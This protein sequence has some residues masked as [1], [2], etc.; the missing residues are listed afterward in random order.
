MDGQTQ[1]KISLMSKCM[2]G[3]FLIMK[4]TPPVGNRTAGTNLTLAMTCNSLPRD[5]KMY[6]L[7]HYTIIFPNMEWLTYG[8]PIPGFS[9]YEDV[10]KVMTS[11]QYD[12]KKIVNDMLN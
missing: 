12:A 5:L 2:Q 8:I 7:I 10:K 9:T 11:S 3:K 4:G 1:Q 6:D